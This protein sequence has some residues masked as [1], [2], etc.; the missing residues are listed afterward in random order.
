MCQAMYLD[1]NTTS[2]PNLFLRSLSTQTTRKLDILWLD[3]DTLG[4]DRGQIRVFK[5]PDQVGFGGF[6]KR[7]NGRGLES[8]IRLEVLGNLTH[9]TLERELADQE[10]GGLLV[11]ADLAER[12]CSG[13]F[14]IKF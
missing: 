7:T 11:S 2:N 6:L 9:E 8:E 14:Y 13:S 1:S 5:Q 4:M 12:D 3:R 10:L